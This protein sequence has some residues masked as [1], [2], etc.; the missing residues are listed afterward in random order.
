MDPS[1]SRGKQPQ[2]VGRASPHSDHG[3]EVV[4]GEMR[5]IAPPKP[6]IEHVKGPKSHCFYMQVQV[7]AQIK[8][9][10]KFNEVEQH[11]EQHE[12][13]KDQRYASQLVKSFGGAQMITKDSSVAVWRRSI[14]LRLWLLDE[15]QN[16]VRADLLWE[17]A[18]SWN[19][20]RYWFHLLELLGFPISTENTV[21]GYHVSP[22]ALGFKH[23]N[24]FTGHHNSTKAMQMESEHRRSFTF[25]GYTDNF[26]V[27]GHG[28]STAIF[29]WNRLLDSLFN[30]AF[31]RSKFK[32]QVLGGDEKKSR[33]FKGTD[34]KTTN[35]HQAWSWELWD[36]SASD[37]AETSGMG[38]RSRSDS[39]IAP[40]L[41]TA[42]LGR[43]IYERLSIYCIIKDMIQDIHSFWL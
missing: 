1:C 4:A 13:R 37:S 6:R 2:L 10:M 32:N 38:T 29:V 15:E 7:Y 43:Q 12:Y 20:Y 11:G 28:F 22:T 18:I 3:K 23:M 25:R 17:F 9:A 36:A 16:G 5:K 42:F 30:F 35:R 19:P 26:L 39:E 27:L 8:D 21:S 24:D 34:R 14:L 40:S 31:T 41:E 33:I